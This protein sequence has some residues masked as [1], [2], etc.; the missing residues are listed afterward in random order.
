MTTAERATIDGAGA[1]ATFLFAGRA[2]FTLES[3]RTGARFTYE[4]TPPRGTRPEQAPVWFVRVL[5]GPDNSNSYSYLGF[6]RDGALIHGG[7]RARVSRDAP[8]FRALDWFLRHIGTTE[9][10]MWHEGRCGRCGR[11][12]TVPESIRTGIGPVCAGRAA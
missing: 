10:A 11:A 5:T 7:Q 6:I 8:S 9:V 12:L 3:V 1:Q 4:V 2:R